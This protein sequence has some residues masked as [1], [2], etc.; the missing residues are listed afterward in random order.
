MVLRPPGAPM[1]RKTKIALMIMLACTVHILQ[2]PAL[3]AAQSAHDL[4]KSTQDQWKR[5]LKNSYEGYERR[6]PSKNSAAEMAFQFCATQ[7][8]AL[9][10]Y[11]AEAGVSR[12]A[13]EQLTAA[14]KKALIGGN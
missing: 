14:T 11:S 8:D 2:I 4:A 5:C 12:S 7:E 6:T 1:R 3:A 10:A 13:F 9:W